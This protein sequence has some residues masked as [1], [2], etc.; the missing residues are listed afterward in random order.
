MKTIDES[1]AAFG[2]LMNEEEIFR[3]AS[4]TFEDICARI[5][6]QKDA[7]ESVLL[8]ELGMRGDAILDKYR[9]TTAP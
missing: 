1:Y 9:E 3:D 7:L 8:E 5:G 4:L 2:R 6:T